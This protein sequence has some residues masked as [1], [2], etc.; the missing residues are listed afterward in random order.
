M[1]EVRITRLYDGVV[2]AWRRADEVERLGALLHQAQRLGRIGGWEENL[3]T[4]EVLWT[5]RTYALF[6]RPPG[7]PVPMAS[8]TR[9]S[10]PTT[11]PR[12]TAS[13]RAA[14]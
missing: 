10:R 6:G 14:A 12:C 9:T 1:L 5:E 4:G 2:I 3:L 13:G 7:D 8:C 11:R